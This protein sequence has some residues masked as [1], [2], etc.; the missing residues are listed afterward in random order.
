MSPKARNT[1]VPP[2][3]RQCK[4]N[5]RDKRHRSALGVFNDHQFDFGGQFSVE[6]FKKK[7][8]LAASWQSS[9]G[10]VAAGN[11][12]AI[13]TSAGMSGAGF[14][15]LTA[16]LACASSATAAVCLTE[17]AKESK[18][19]SRDLGNNR[20][21]NGGGRL[22]DDDD[23]DNNDNDGDNDNG[24]GGD[25]DHGGT[26]G[27]RKTKSKVNNKDIMEK[28]A[29]KN[30]HQKPHGEETPNQLWWWSCQRGSRKQSG[31]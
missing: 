14:A 31:D 26:N 27:P 3:F 13:C 28:R 6:A 24:D 15:T 11:L 5:I 8:S 20:G 17:A 21:N 18:G 29:N 2:V 16:G 23:D 19:S 12:F 1:F 22:D 9:I 10:N 7:S 30:P 4:A 25:D